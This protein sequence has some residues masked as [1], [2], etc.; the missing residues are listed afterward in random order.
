MP[1]GRMQHTAALS[2]G[3]SCSAYAANKIAFT[4]KKKKIL[5][6]FFR[7]Q[8]LWNKTSELCLTVFSNWLITFWNPSL[9]IC[10]AASFDETNDLPIKFLGCATS[11]GIP[12]PSRHNVHIYLRHSATFPAQPC[13]TVPLCAA[14][15]SVDIP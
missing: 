9:I 7:L 5:H 13:R 14:W 6:I 3:E 12:Q 11:S 4:W 10:R 1:H 8:K 15:H 2:H